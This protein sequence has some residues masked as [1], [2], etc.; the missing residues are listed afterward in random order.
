[1]TKRRDFIKTGAL[2]AAGLAI[3]GK[4]LS[5]KSYQP[6]RAPDR[7]NLAVIGIRN[8]G[9]VHIDAWCNLRNSHNVF[10][11]TI[12]DTDEALF[13]SRIR[14][15]TDKGGSKPLTEWDL[16]RV[17]DDKEIHAVSIAAPNHWHALATVWACQAGKHVYVEKPAS[18]NIWEGRKMVEAARKANVRVQCGMNNRSSANVREAINFLHDGGI[19]ELFMARALCFKARDS[20]GMAKNSVPP[21]TFHYDLWLT[22]N[23]GLITKTAITPALVLGYGKRDTAIP[24]SPAGYSPLGTATRSSC[25]SLFNRWLIRPQQG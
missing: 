23:G 11:K 13:G 12:C 8:Q 15:V 6:L 16:R 9:S 25:I 7:I 17:F 1:M 24:T 3:G 4:E 14:M 18:H 22:G 21:P 20:Y 10:L 19:G 5:A 2:G